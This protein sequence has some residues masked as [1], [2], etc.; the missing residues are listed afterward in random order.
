M[1]DSAFCLDLQEKYSRMGDVRVTGDKAEFVAL[2]IQQTAPNYFSSDNQKAVEEQADIIAKLYGS[3]KIK[4]RVVDVVIPDTYTYF[5]I[6]ELPQLKEKELLSAIRYQS[7]EF[8]PMP[9][10]ETNLDIDIISEDLATRRLTALIVAVPKKTAS[11]IEKTLDAAGL[12]A[13]SLE[14]ELTSFGRL[15]ADK[16]GKTQKGNPTLIINLGFLS[17]SLYF[18]HPETSLITFA[19]NFK[20]G[21]DLFLRDIRVNLNIDEKKSLEILKTVGFSTNASYNV[22]EILT[23]ILHQFTDEARKFITVVKERLNMNITSVQLY[24]YDNHISQFN[25]KVGEALQIPTSSFNLGSVVV[26]NPVSQS[27]SGDL[28]SFASVVGGSL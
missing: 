9:L 12:Q 3:L 19:R 27:F 24:N 16:F 25:I 26:Q 7:D 4:K 14:N 15:Y 8:I 13:G 11:T 18:I 20:I 1:S 10:E 2:G 17:S 22:G 21:L 5:Q 28:S 6:L 23:P